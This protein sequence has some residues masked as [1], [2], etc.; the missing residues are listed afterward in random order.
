M[1]IKHVVIG[2]AVVLCGSL[3]TLMVVPRWRIQLLGRIQGERFIDGMPLNYWDWELWHKE[4][5][6]AS[7]AALLQLLSVESVSERASMLLRARRPSADE[8]T[9][10]LL[11]LLRGSNRNLQMDAAYAPAGVVSPGK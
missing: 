11:P 5:S 9:P 6:T 3:V 1:K 4:P 7:N 2:L 10:A 8:A